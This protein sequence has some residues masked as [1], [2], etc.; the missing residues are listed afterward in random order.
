MT[1]ATTWRIEGDVT[2]ACNCATAC[3]CNF[4]SDP[5]TVPCQAVLAWHVREGQY[6]D[7]QLGGLNLVLYA[8]IPGNVFAGDWTVGVYLD[9]RA[10]PQ[11]AEAL[12]AIFSGQAGGWP[13]ALS[14]LIAHPLPPKQVPIKFELA[15][16]DVRVDVPGLLQVASEHVPNPMGGVL[17]TKVSGLVVPFYNGTVDVR[18]TT[19][20]KLTD[21]NLSFEYAGRSSFIGQFD[22]SGP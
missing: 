13:A 20:L 15:D 6:G 17:E 2:E 19:T 22:Y 4:G 8:S 9:E 16:G 10:N 18:R 11:Q 14:A 7:T 1:N 5:T 3:P 12:G 21:P